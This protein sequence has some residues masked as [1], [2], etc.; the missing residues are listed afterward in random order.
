MAKTY[1]PMTPQSVGRLVGEVLREQSAMR[2]RLDSAPTVVLSEAPIA[3]PNDKTVMTIEF[4]GSLTSL[5]G[6]TIAVSR[7][8]EL[9]VLLARLHSMLDTAMERHR[10]QNHG[11][12]G[13]ASGP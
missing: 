5:R 7:E 9:S 10:Q 4:A 13:K 8:V 11:G 6:L 2:R 12:M 3:D 1:P